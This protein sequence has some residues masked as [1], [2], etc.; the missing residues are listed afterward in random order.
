MTTSKGAAPAAPFAVALADGSERMTSLDVWLEYVCPWCSY[1]VTSEEGDAERQ[2]VSREYAELAGE[3]FVPRDF[4]QRD[5]EVYDRRGCANPA[6]LVNMTAEQ[7]T[8]QCERAAAAD[9]ERER[10]AGISRWHA[11]YMAET[12]R[13]E[14]EAWAAVRI[15]AEEAGQCLACL[16]ASYWQS[17]PNLVRH[18]SPENCPSVRKYAA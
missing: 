14:D 11:N 12:Q 10:Q 18:R 4:S 16:R 13:R 17:R 6:C 2:R 8:A 15:R 9:A 5:R 7:L 3:T 1:V